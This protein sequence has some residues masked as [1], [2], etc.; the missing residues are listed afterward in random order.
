MPNIFE[1]GQHRDNIKMFAL[2]FSGLIMALS[3]SFILISFLLFK[4]LLINIFHIVH[5][6][7]H[8]HILI[9]LQKLWLL[10][11]ESPPIC[12]NNLFRGVGQYYS[13]WFRYN[14]FSKLI[15]IIKDKDCKLLLFSAFKFYKLI[16][17]PDFFHLVFVTI[18]TL[19]QVICTGPTYCKDLFIN[20]LCF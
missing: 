7:L 13:L 9:P 5:K 15:V 3:S 8:L 10:F 12:C 4:S 11:N 14:N 6:L 2:L 19:Y 1:W 17:K 16:T 20:V 18:M